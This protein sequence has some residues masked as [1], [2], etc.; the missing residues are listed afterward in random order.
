MTRDQEDALAE[1][2]SCFC[3]TWHPDR[4]DQWCEERGM[5]EEHMEANVRELQG[6]VGL[7][8]V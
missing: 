8:L 5:M 4:V 3:D 7:D 2:L 1:V 6:L